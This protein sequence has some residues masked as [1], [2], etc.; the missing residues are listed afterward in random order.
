MPV[1]SRRQR[2]AMAIAKYEPGRLFKRNHGLLKMD[3]DDLS[4][5]IETSEASLPKKVR[6]KRKGRG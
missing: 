5:F 4:E 2:R 3:K 1:K 6:K